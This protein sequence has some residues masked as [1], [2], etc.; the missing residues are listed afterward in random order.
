MSYCLIN[1]KE[2]HIV[3]FSDEASKDCKE[4]YKKVDLDLIEAHTWRF[5]ICKEKGLEENTG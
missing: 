5:P 1:K 4:F 3:L 2:L